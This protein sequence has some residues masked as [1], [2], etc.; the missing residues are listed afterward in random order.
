[1]VSY[2]PIPEDRHPTPRG[3]LF[4]SNQK[5]CVQV[6]TLL[7]IAIVS[8]AP[9][10]ALDLYAGV[11]DVPAQGDAERRAATPDALVNV[12]QKQSGQWE[13]P[14]DP[15][16]EAALADPDSML[17]AYQYR[18]QPVLLPG[19]VTEKRLQLVASFVPA[20][21]DRLVREMQLP[22]WRAQREPVVAWV[23]VEEAG[24]RQ[25]MPVEYSDAW[26]SMTRIADLRGLPLAWPDLDDTARQSLDLQLLWGGYT[27]QLAPEGESLGGT[28]IIAARREGMD[29]SVR[30]NWIDGE[31]SA[32]WRTR[33]PDLS[34]A[35]VEGT[36]QLV[37]HVAAAHSIG[38]AGLVAT[39]QQLRVTGLESADEYA[40]VLTYLEGLGLVDELQVRRA[41][42]DGVEFEL[43]LN[44]DPGFLD[45][46]IRSDGLLQA[47]DR[48]REYHLRRPEREARSETLTGNDETV[49]PEAQP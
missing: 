38:A 3:I 34:Q 43:A 39:T 16:L 24:L 1:M 27:D 49:S 6:F 30:W 37:D 45:Q 23:V 2:L 33:S 36:H 26:S 44:A 22:R 25:L 40:R 28:V 17:V 11:A 42:P 19:G 35:L 31:H 21:V 47:G 14:A 32:G 4:M 15:A 41:G 12:L 10:I 46:V 29:W 9:A 7:V 48:D 8:A 18:E 13:I 20:S 5:I